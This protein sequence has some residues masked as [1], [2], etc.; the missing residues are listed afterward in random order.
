MIPTFFV[1]EIETNHVPELFEE[2]ED[3]GKPMVIQS[4]SYSMTKGLLCCSC[5]LQKKEGILAPV[6]YPMHLIGVALEGNV[7]EI[8]GIKIRLHLKIDDGKQP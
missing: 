8:S 1:T 6:R 7:L 4:F 2:V 3:A 5:R